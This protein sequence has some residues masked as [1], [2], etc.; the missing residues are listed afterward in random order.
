MRLLDVT[1]PGRI[2][3]FGLKGVNLVFTGRLSLVKTK[4]AP[5]LQKSEFGFRNDKMSTQ[6]FEIVDAGKIAYNL[7]EVTAMAQRA[8]AEAMREVATMIASGFASL[9]SKISAWNGRRAATAQLMSLDDRMLADIG[10]GRGDIQASIAG[11]MV[12]DAA[13]RNTRGRNA[14]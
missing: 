10:I 9:V 8:R 6:Q 1:R 3:R 5:D 12:Q 14:A 13:N 11:R 2:S 7:D 4:F